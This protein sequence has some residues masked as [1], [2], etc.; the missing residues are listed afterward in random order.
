M[1]S[2]Q[3][4]LHTQLKSEQVQ[5]GFESLLQIAARRQHCMVKMKEFCRKTEEQRCSGCP[6][7]MRIERFEK[8]D[9]F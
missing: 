6:N 8:K 1:V 7:F 9:V 5:R 4:I 3:E 2:S